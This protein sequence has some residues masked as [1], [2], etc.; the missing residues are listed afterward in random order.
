LFLEEVLRVAPD[1]GTIDMLPHSLEAV[2]G[3]QI[4]ALSPLARRLLRCAAVLGGSFR[5]DIFEQV[6]AAEGL[7]ADAATREALKEFFEPSSRDRLRFRHA[8]VRDVAYEGLP[9]GRR[10]ELHR[11]AAKILTRA[12]GASPETVADLLALHYARARDHALAWHYGVIAGD[13]A[14]EAFANPE[15]AANYVLA[16]DSA[17]RVPDIPGDDRAGVRGP[18]HPRSAGLPPPRQDARRSFSI[19]SGG[20]RRPT[21]SVASGMGFV[22]LREGVH[23]CLAPV[24]A[25]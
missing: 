15:A 16:L 7:S 2:I 21:S 11:S 8:V 9:Y 1:T 12:A 6:V 14:R 10:R 5:A 22:M 25:L 13:R 23:A 18:C 3:V 20:G 4:D 24:N 17:R 19:V